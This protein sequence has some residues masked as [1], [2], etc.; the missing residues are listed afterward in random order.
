MPPKSVSCL[1]R[2]SSA[3]GC[4]DPIMNLNC[5]RQLA[6]LPLL[7]YSKGIFYCLFQEEKGN[8][9]CCGDYLSALTNELLC[10]S[11]KID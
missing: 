3:R 8:E 4:N 6:R 5:I 7:K 2:L 11:L 9:A 10:L 1:Y